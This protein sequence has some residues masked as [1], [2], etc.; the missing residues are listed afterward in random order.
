MD[1]TR[2]LNE[3]SVGVI[4]STATSAAAAPI[5]NTRAS[6]ASGEGSKPA[7]V[8]L[9]SPS[10][11]V[12]GTP[13]SVRLIPN[14]SKVPLTTASA[15]STGT[16][17]SHTATATAATTDATTLSRN[18]RARLSFGQS[19]VPSHSLRWTSPPASVSAAATQRTTVLV[20]MSIS[21]LHHDRAG[22]P[23]MDPADV[24]VGSRFGEREAEGVTLRELGRCR[25]AGVGA[26]LD[27]VVHAV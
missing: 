8:N 18:I 21:G 25:D 6:S 22:H 9:P 24:V 26:E 16:Q 11:S 5:S 10:T 4:A 7:S 17:W 1:Q 27:A 15:P 12:N 13:V 3:T 23:G 19:L 20:S 2:R 14:A